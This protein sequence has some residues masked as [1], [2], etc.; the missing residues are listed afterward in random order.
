GAPSGGVPSGAPAGVAAAA[1]A[2]GGL[3]GKKIAIEGFGP[4][5]PALAAAAADQGARI[6]AVSTTKG[7]MMDEGG[8]DAAELRSAWAA[9]GEAMVGDDA[10]PAWKVFGAE[11]DVLFTG[12]KT[13]AIN[14]ETAARL[15]ATAVVP[16]AALPF[17]ARA[18]AVMERADV[19]V[20]PDFV[21]LAAP[22]VGSWPGDATDADAVIAKATGAIQAAIEETSDH[23]DGAFLGACYRAE[24]FLG[25]W[26]ESLPFGRPLAS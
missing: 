26:R 7:A 22:A 17:T 21:A 3:D 19:T 13:G 9:S 25:T 2:T 23:A 15:A 1:G 14:H 16:H 8:L 10:D 24:A 6:V 18:L 11:A 5:G 12:S 20:V 4:T